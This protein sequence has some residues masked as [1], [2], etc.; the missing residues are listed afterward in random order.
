MQ[1]HGPVSTSFD[2]DSPGKRAGF[3]I[4]TVVDE[5]EARRLIE[6]DSFFTEGLIDDLTILAW[7]PLFGSLSG[8]A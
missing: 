5:S 4:M 8:P 2:L 7:T 1:T 6:Q 3:I